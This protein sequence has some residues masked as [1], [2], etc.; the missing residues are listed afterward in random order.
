MGKFSC[1][2]VTR[3]HLRAPWF[4]ECACERER[5]RFSRSCRTV[6]EGEIEGLGALKRRCG[7]D[8]NG[9][10]PLFSRRPFAARNAVRTIPRGERK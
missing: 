5:H 1:M 10:I 8:R 2:P 9:E 6:R 4:G 7:T 3:L